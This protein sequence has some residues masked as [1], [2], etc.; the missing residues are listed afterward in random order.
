MK[1]TIN[2]LE[3]GE[4]GFLHAQMMQKL[5][6]GFFG[7]LLLFVVVMAVF[8]AYLSWRTQ[9]VNDDVQAHT[10]IRSNAMIS[11]K[12]QSMSQQHEKLSESLL[13]ASQAKTVM[14]KMK[15]TS[16]ARILESFS[17]A[18]TKG[19]WVTH[20]DSRPQKETIEM[21]GQAENG[22]A[23]MSMLKKLAGLPGIKGLQFKLVNLKQMTQDTY[24]FRI[25]GYY[26]QL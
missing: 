7:I 12:I 26:E 20:I 25:M 17:L 14:L 24:E 5:I 2:L 18:H 19:A 21:M 1:Q 9:S 4:S 3:H 11:P 6:I 16:F 8:M 13:I 22:D 15:F 23:V 10:T